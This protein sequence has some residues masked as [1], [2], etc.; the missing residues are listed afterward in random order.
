MTCLPDDGAEADEG[1]IV[2]LGVAGGELT[3]ILQQGATDRLGAAGG[4]GQLAKQAPFVAGFVQLFAE[5]A[6]VGDSVG[7]HGDD[8]TGLKYDLGLACTRR[9][10]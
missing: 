3:N 2:D 4:F 10:A 5:V 9:R 6:G 1:D 8:V 7:E